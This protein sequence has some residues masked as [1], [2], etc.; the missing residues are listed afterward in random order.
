M[1]ARYYFDFFLYSLYLKKLISKSAIFL[2]SKRY[3]YSLSKGIMVV[4]E[5]LDIQLDT[6]IRK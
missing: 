6:S 5:V 2:L 4:V 1:K 3:E